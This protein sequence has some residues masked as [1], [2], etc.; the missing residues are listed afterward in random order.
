MSLCDYPVP[1]PNYHEPRDFKGVKTKARFM[2][3][4]GAAAA[5]VAL[6]MGDILCPVYARGGRRAASALEYNWLGLVA[7]SPNIKGLCVYQQLRPFP[8]P[9]MYN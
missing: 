8:R 2:H 7:S 9:D 1:R 4:A 3:A 6:R 5:R